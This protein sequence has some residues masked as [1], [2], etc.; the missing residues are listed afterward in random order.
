[1]SS[2]TMTLD[3]TGAAAAPA[4]PGS[5]ATVSRAVGAL[6][7]LGFLSY[8]TGFALVSGQVAATG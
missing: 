1:M 5:R 6:F 2:D 3:R 8:G 4:H 7:L